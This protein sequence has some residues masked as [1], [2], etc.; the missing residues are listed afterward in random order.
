ML[1]LRGSMTPGTRARVR[2]HAGRLAAVA[3]GRVAARGRVPVRAA[4]RAL[5][6]RR[7][8]ADDAPEGAARALPDG[9]AGGAARGSATCCASTSRSTSRSCSRREPAIPRRVR[10]AAVRL[11]PGGRAGRAGRRALDDARGAAAARAPA[12][13]CSS[14][15]RG[16]C[17]AS[18]CRAG[19]P[20]S[21]P[22]RATGPRRVPTDRAARGRGGRRV[23][24]HPRAGN[25]RA[26]GR[27]GRR[28]DGARRPRPRPG[29]R[30]RAGAALVRD[31][32]A[33]PGAGAA[34]GHGDRGLRGV[35]RPCDVPGPRGPDRRVGELRDVQARLVERLPACARDCGSRRRAPT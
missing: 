27:R 33:D 30:G 5:D 21:G 4:R 15:R 13:R 2:R 29:A 18:R 3:G 1:A 34:G 14:A 16:R 28:P 6:G 23:A 10:R 22:R 9:L 17:C 7:H 31:P 26:L 35:R 8:R 12:A 11:L 19:G 20:A 32:V 25:T 24:A